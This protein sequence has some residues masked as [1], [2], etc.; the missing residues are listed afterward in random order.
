M[1][2]RLSKFDIVVLAG[3][4]GLYG[5]FALMTLTRLSIWFDE[6]FSV[7]IAGFSF[8][9]IAKYT[10]VDVHPPLYYWLLKM[11]MVLFGSS[12]FAVRSL[13]VVFGLLTITVSYFLVKRLF[14]RRVAAVSSLLL[15]FSPLFLQLAQEAR[16]YSLA[17][18][19]GAS[20]TYA[21]VRARQAGAKK[22][23]WLVYGALLAAGMWT[24]YFTAL[25]WLA[26]AAWLLIDVLRARPRRFLSALPWRGILYAYGV[27]LLLFAPWIANFWRQLTDVQGGF[28][29]P[30]VDNWSIPNFFVKSLSLRHFDNL[31]VWTVVVLSLVFVAAGFLAYRAYSAMG[32]KERSYGLLF[33][34]IAALPPALLWVLSKPPFKP[35][36]VDRYLITSAVS[37]ALLFGVVMVRGR[38]TRWLRV[39]FGAMLATVVCFGLLS[40]QTRSGYNEFSGQPN[41]MR[42]AMRLVADNGA[43]GQPIIVDSPWAFYEA[44]FYRSDQNPVYFIDDPNLRS[45]GALQ[46][47]F[48]TPDVAITDTDQFVAQHENVWYV[49]RAGAGRNPPNLHWQ[50]TLH[51][52][53]YDSEGSIT[54]EAIRYQTR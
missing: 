29:V 32:Q 3:C 27:A 35:V 46:T 19:I 43:T 15:S 10:A 53:V 31:P 48:A 5:G 49:G 54:Y 9:D 26:H 44:A 51:L 50:P 40:V 23:W 14:G 21:L 38:A 1:K 11:W 7:Y 30:H 18:F 39:G 8:G 33:L 6:A 28:W 34:M 37:T 24:H 36:F 47:I 41:D 25:V 42:A 12:E 4:L 52:Y 13:S 17:A 22:W 16:M 45:V 2:P 20:A